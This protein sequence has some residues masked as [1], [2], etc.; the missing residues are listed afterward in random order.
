MLC[1]VLFSCSSIDAGG[2]GEFLTNLAWAED[3]TFFSVANSRFFA[4][5]LRFVCVRS[6]YCVHL[7][8]SSCTAKR[9]QF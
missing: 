7:C 5:R 9:R 1:G 6:L 8:I 2:K 3:R 4:G